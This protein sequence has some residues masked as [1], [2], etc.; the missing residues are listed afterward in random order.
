MYIERD[1]FKTI[2]NEVILAHFQQMK[3]IVFFVIL[4]AA[5][6]FNIISYLL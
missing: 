3:N 6:I 5:T 2:I 1:V 4:V